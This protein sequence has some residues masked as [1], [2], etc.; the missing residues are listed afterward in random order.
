MG[1]EKRAK[2]ERER[3][4]KGRWIGRGLDFGLGF[5]LKLVNTASY[6]WNK[7]Y[8]VLFSIVIKFMFTLTVKTNWTGQQIQQQTLD[9]KC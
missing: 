8:F 1:A 6:C 7:N 5:E 4:K 3:A 9:N 2:R